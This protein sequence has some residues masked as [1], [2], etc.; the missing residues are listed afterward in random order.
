MA[1]N[2]LIFVYVVYA[3]VSVVLTIW[4]ARTLSRNGEVFLDDVFIENPRMARSVNSLLVVG[5]YLMNLGYALV[6]LKA[7][8]ISPTGTEATVHLPSGERL[9]VAP[10]THTW[11]CRLAT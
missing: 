6:T 11:T 2:N 4:L 10:A 7:D 1:S 9:I 3:L 8:V 5:F